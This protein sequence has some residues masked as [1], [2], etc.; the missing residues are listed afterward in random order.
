M[1]LIYQPAKYYFGRRHRPYWGPTCCISHPIPTCTRESAPEGRRFLSDTSRLLYCSVETSSK[2][3]RMRQ[4]NKCLLVR[5]MQNC[6]ICANVRSCKKCKNF[7]QKLKNVQNLQNVQ[8]CRKY[9]KLQKIWKIVQIMQ[10]KTAKCEKIC[11]V[12]WKMTVQKTE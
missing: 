11:K 2:S 12:V 1:K 5:N 10:Q 8:N 6:T 3:W 7:V 9:A 4:L